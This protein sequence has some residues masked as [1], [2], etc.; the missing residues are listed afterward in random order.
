MAFA[1]K[2][3]NRAGIMVT[4]GSGFGSWGEGFIRFALTVPEARIHQAVGRLEEMELYR[5]RLL[6]W[7]RKKEE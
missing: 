6:Q 1:G 2:L 3:V 4:P 5:N 7:L